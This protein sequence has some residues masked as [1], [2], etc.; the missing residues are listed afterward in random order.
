MSDAIKLGLFYHR[1]LSNFFEK[2]VFIDHCFQKNDIN[3]EFL[4]AKPQN[5]HKNVK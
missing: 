2:K 4:V 5:F 3:L 1:N